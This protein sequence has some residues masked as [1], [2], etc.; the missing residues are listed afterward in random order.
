MQKI[1]YG[2]PEWFLAMVDTDHVHAI[3][4]VITQWSLM[5]SSIEDCIAQA[6]RIRVDYSRALC[7]Q[8]QVQSKLDVLGAVISRDNPALGAQVRKVA[9]YVR[10]CLLG[11]RNLVAHGGWLTDPE[12][13]ETFVLRSIARGKLISQAQAF[14]LK[15]L[16]ELAYDI[17]DVTAWFVR[18]AAGLPPLRK[19]SEPIPESPEIQNPR[20]CSTRKQRALQPPA[21][22]PKAPRRKRKGS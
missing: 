22:P 1:K 13:K 5:E 17:A 21:F 11:K 3:G 2:D 10:E 19:L 4:M 18:V 12:T 6:A 15:A 14:P 7:A 20:D 8:M 9:D 16:H